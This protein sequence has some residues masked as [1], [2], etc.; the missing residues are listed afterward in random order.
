MKEA[1]KTWKMRFDVEVQSPHDFKKT[2]DILTS[3]LWIRWDRVHVT[4]IISTGHPDNVK[5]AD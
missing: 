4:K 3:R 2:M 1:L 5:D